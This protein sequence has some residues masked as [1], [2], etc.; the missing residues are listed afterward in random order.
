MAQDS[1]AA[2]QML[3]T[4][5]KMESTGK[6]FY[7]KAAAEC[8]TPLGAEIFKTL[9]EDEI[10]HAERIS[11]IYEEIK[12]GKPFG[13]E[14]KTFKIEH[15]DVHQ[16]FRELAYQHGPNV[17]ASAGDIQALDVG[18][19]LEQKSV[20]FYSAELKRSTDAFERA[21]LEE[22]I[23]EERTH[24]TVLQDMKLYLEDPAA[25]F[26]EKERSGYDGA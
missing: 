5:L 11:K 24:Y 15:K 1:K 22:L 8:R 3:L 4:A 6:E 16:V 7:G 20:T 9:R 23:G 12:G 25:W 17:R 21:F 26:S 10:V 19:D 13:E 18:I 2:M 14:W